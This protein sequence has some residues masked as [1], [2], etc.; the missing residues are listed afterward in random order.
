MWQMSSPTPLILSC[1]F[2]VVQLT[3]FYDRYFSMF[4]LRN[5]L[6]KYSLLLTARSVTILLLTFRSINHLEL[7]FMQRVTYRLSSFP[8]MVT[9]KTV[10]C[11]FC[12]VFDKTVLNVQQG[13]FDSKS[14]I[15]VYKWDFFP[16]L[17]FVPHWSLYPSLCCTTLS[18]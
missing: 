7:I 3:V 2:I 13:H 6:L 1:D 4:H 16:G 5:L 12:F 11:C 15:H 10:L 18:S 8:Q 14:G 17:C 9:S